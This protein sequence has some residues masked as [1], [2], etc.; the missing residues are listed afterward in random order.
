MNY[1]NGPRAE[2]DSLAEE[3]KNGVIS[4]S[5]ANNALRKLIK[6]NEVEAFAEQHLADVDVV[7]NAAGLPTATS[8]DFAAMLGANAQLPLFLARASHVAG[9]KRA[10]LFLD[11]EL[12]RLAAVGDLVPGHRGQFCVI[13][14]SLCIGVEGGAGFFHFDSTG[15]A[16]GRVV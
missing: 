7:I 14:R 11:G 13:G 5:V 1:V 2:Y 3:L 12:L 8:T 9:V 10:V 6:Q 16:H 15:P 4:Q